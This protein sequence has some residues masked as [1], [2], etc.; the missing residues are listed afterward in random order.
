MFMTKSHE[1]INTTYQVSRNIN[2]VI[3]CINVNGFLN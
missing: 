2:F 1:I 3:K